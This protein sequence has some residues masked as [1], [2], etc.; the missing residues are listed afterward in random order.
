VTE[1]LRATAL[2][3]VFADFGRSMALAEERQL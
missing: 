2:I 3:S 1:S